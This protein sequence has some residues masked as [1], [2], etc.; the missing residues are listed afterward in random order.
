M[1]TILCIDLDDTLLTWNDKSFIEKATQ[2]LCRSITSIPEDECFS[3]MD[4]A[5]RYLIQREVS[6][7]TL[8]ELFYDHFCEGIEALQPKIA[9]E[10]QHFYETGYQA[11][12]QYTSA[13]PAGVWLIEEAI[14]RGYEIVIATN[15]LFPRF[16]LEQRLK[17]AGLDRYMDHF[18]FITS[19][20]EIH[21][22]K[23]DPAYFVEILGRLGWQEDNRVFMVGDSLE[24]D[25]IPASK[26]GIPAYWLK[27]AAL[28]E[29]L[30]QACASGGYEGVFSWIEKTLQKNH[31]DLA[32]TG[33]YDLLAHLKTA[34]LI[35]DGICRS[36]TDE[37]GC[38]RPDESEW[39]L[40]EIVCHL[41]DT[42]HEV[43]LPRFKEAFEQGNPF[44]PP[45]DTSNWSHERDYRNEDG[46]E[47]AEEFLDTRKRMIGLLKQHAEEWYDTTAR[48][49]IFGPVC[50]A[51]LMEFIITHDQ[52]HIRQAYDTLLRV[53]TTNRP[54]TR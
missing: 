34:P 53:K 38:S 15:P 23:P 29:G 52:M 12:Q 4:S 19:M 14:R 44:L 6:S 24:M 36:V 20:E 21:F 5:I 50:V 18:L 51:D 31:A 41:R 35:F 37:T 40:V 17:W 32:H 9:D 16:A 42:D 27:D 2:A 30:N 48:H 46:H 22:T 49:S 3:R 13:L 8:S 26:A 45:I 33:Q 11:L 54:Y 10:I 1:T 43:N 7:R 47:A 28:P 25:I 39:S